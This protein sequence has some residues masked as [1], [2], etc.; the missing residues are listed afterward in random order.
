M[1]DSHATTLL[2]LEERHRLQVRDLDEAHKHALQDL[3][4]QL[5]QV[6]A[7]QESL[8][9]AKLALAREGE[10]E[11]SRMA[12]AHT[13]ALQAEQEEHS[14]RLKEVQARHT[15]AIAK[16]NRTA[17]VEL[18]VSPYCLIVHRLCMSIHYEASFMMGFPL[19]I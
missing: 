8:S 14:R 19:Y 17:E 4:A 12:A 3:Q 6:E 11:R 18:Q 2:A 10:E 1:N 16:D 15:E 5:E 13:A 7:A 9:A